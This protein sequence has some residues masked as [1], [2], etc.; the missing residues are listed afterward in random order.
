M[1]PPPDDT[2]R[3]RI[4][5][6]FDHSA[7]AY[8]R[9]VKANPGY[10]EHLRRSVARLRLPGNGAG[11]RLLDLGCGTGAST[12]AL[13]DA[14]P[15]AEI[16]GVDASAGMLATARAKPWPAN[17][18]FVRAGAEELAEAG[19]TGPFDAVLAAY[20]LRNCADRDAALA[21]MRDLLRPGGRLAV[22][23]YSVADS[24]AARAVWTAVCWSVIIPFGRAVSGRADLYRYLWRSVLEFDGAERLAERM[25]AVGLREVKVLPMT[26]WQTGIVHTFLGRRAREGEDAE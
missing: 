23:E 7:A 12:A 24:P 10:H 17:V 16:V 14:A 18:R 19:V 5:A 22:H 4:T 26:G 6:E 2:R 3:H 20:L 15:K 25:R 13:L 21:D 8:D 1:T 11:L 9:L